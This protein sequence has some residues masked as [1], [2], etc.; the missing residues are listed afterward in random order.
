[1]RLSARSVRGGRRT[2]VKRILCLGL[3]LVSLIAVAAFGQ[4]PAPT[5]EVVLKMTGAIALRNAEGVFTFDLDML[6]ALPFVAYMVT[7]PWLGDQVYGGVRLADLLSYVGI[8]ADAKRVVIVASDAKEFPIAMKDA[9][10]YP[11]LIAFTSDG[12]PIKASKGGPL[13]LVYPYQIEGMEALYAPEQW[14]W[15]VIEIRVEF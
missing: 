15:Y 2:A 6:K 3:V 12:N 13:K 5:G 10:Y 14:S 11:I 1:M 9:L 4:V 7:D 8:P